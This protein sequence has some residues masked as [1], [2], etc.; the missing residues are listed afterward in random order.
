MQVTNIIWM[1]RDSLVIYLKNMMVRIK[2]RQ[3]LYPKD[4]KL[5]NNAFNDLSDGKEIACNVPIQLVI[6]KQDKNVQGSRDLLNKSLSIAG[7]N[8]CP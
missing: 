7:T 1:Y 3:V 5:I 2:Q 6:K 8:L 4:K